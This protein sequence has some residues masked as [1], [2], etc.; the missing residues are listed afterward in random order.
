MQ[1]S[2]IPGGIL[3]HNDKKFT[4]IYQ[5]QG[6]TGACLQEYVNYWPDADES[7]ADRRLVIDQLKVCT[8]H[9]RIALLFNYPQSCRAKEANFMPYFDL[10]AI[11]MSTKDRQACWISF[12]NAQTDELFGRA[13]TRNDT[14]DMQSSDFIKVMCFKPDHW[15]LIEY[16]SAG[17]QT[18]MTSFAQQFANY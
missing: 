14:V 16:N 15:K 18:R 1:G 3:L 2:K 17:L 8:R 5:G 11:S 12:S 4:K 13:L 7:G 6:G 9:R 10:N